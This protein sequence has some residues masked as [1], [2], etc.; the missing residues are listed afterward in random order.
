MAEKLTRAQR[1]AQS[2]RARTF[3]PLRRALRVP[4]WGDLTLRLGAA[5]FLIAIVVLVHWIDR[6]G[7]KDS[8]DGSI[9]FLDVVYF[10]MISITTT[11]FGDIAP[12]SDQSRLV[13][14][15]IVTPIRVMVLFIFVGAAYNYLLKRGWEKWRMARIQEKLSDHIVVLGYGIS[16]SEAVQELIDRGTNPECIV[17][18]DT[19]PERLAA[20]EEVGCNVIE[21]DAT[22]DE[23]LMAVRIDKAR[24]VLVSAGRDDSSILIVLTARHLAPGVPI[25]V[26]IRAADNE[27][28]ARQAGAD[29]VINPVR[30][31]GLL[32]AGSAQGAHIS[33]Y[34]ADLASVGGKVQLV[35]RP[36]QLTEI[37]R[38]LDNLASGGKGLRIYRGGHAFG[39]WEAEAKSLQ[40]GD[41]VV[42]I[43]PTDE[44]ERDAPAPASVE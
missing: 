20:A 6:D 18:M 24:T 33:D 14:A 15:V 16:G 35:E 1:H 36:V 10:T 3:T 42:E 32:L 12:V 37:G 19:D 9:S 28:L 26:V 27:D 23:H 34:L 30:F 22:R 39:F 44:T 4:V 38:S 43:S 31:T 11:G 5:L 2:V 25:S 29:N 41:T 17:V 8:H 40:V 21:A 7:L 13:E